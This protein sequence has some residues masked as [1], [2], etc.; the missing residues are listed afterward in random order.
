MRRLLK[1][2]KGWRFPGPEFSPERWAVIRAK[3]RGRF[4]LGEAFPYTVYTIAIYD[5]VTQFRHPGQAFKFGFYVFQF[6]LG[7]I[8]L[9]YSIWRNQE[10]KY[11]KALN[12][13]PQASV[14]RH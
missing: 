2:F 8:W 13:S 4:V 1:A 11:K 3:G 7:G 6:A 5:V 10:D 14:Q 9:G 12:P